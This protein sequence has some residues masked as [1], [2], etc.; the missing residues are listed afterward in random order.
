LKIGNNE[1]GDEE[2][3]HGQ[4]SESEVLFEE[5]DG[6]QTLRNSAR[7]S[8]GEST[9]DNFRQPFFADAPILEELSWKKE[10]SRR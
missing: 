8:L 10:D 6:V 7:G 1:I 3:T 4:G 2:N 5:R 9:P